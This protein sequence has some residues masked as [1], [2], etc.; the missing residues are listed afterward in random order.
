LKKIQTFLHKDIQEIKVTK[1]DYQDT[2]NIER[3]RKNDYMSIVEDLE[4]YN[5]KKK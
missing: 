3:D 4:S 1:T 5:K 2:L